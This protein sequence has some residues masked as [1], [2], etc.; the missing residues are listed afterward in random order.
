MSRW[1][2]GGL[3]AALV[4]YLAGLAH[5]EM[6]VGGQIGYAM[7]SGLTDVS[8]THGRSGLTLSDIDLQ[9]SVAFGAKI[10]TFFGERPGFEW[11]GVEAE[12]YQTFPNIKGQTLTSNIP[13]KF[14]G[15]ISGA[16]FSV[17][18]VAANVIVRI[19]NQTIQPYAGLGI[20]G[21]LGYISGKNATFDRDTAL[22]PSFNILAGVRYF[23]TQN[24]AVFGEYKYNVMTFSFPKNDLTATY[25]ANI[26]MVGLSFHFPR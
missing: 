18:T 1:Q 11:F 24:I 10:G 2:I 23:A 4:I 3:S 17:T 22:A 19:P 25:R 13:N 6:Y 15:A 16:P 20:G 7:T 9:N 5:A 21:N 8:G 12:L 14:S 26:F